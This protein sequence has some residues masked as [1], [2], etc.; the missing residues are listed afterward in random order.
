MVGLQL[1][2]MLRQNYS[3][4]SGVQADIK[5]YSQGHFKAGQHV[6]E[7]RQGTTE[8]TLLWSKPNKLRLTVVTSTN[9]LLIGA[10]MATPDGQQI[11]ARAKGILGIFPLHFSPTEPR[12]SNNRNHPF[13]ENNPKT[14]IERLTGANAVWTVVADSNIE[15][16]AVK[17]LSVDGVKRLDRDVTREVVAIDPAAGSLRG[18]VMYA[19]NTRVVDYHF[20]SFRWSPSITEDMFSL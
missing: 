18:V 1:L 17:L 14:Q 2:N 5:S 19:G 12:L 6:D 15:G 10:A 13:T 4:C 16:T 3:R 9:A 20:M 7:L 11:T 8:A